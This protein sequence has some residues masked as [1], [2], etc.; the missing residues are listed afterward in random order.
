MAMKFE[1]PLGEESSYNDADHK[2]YCLSKKSDIT[3]EATG[4]SAGIFAEAGKLDE[5]IQHFLHGEGNNLG[6]ANGLKLEPRIYHTP[7]LMKLEKFQR[8]CGFEVGMKWP[9][10][11]QG[12]N[13]K[14]DQVM[15]RYKTGWDM[16]PLII[17]LHDGEYELNDGNHRYEALRRLGIEEHWVIIWETA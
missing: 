4:K 6:F 8:I 3:F 2:C 11:E 17:G 5:W 16:P 9:V 1:I 10:D 15:K 7:K 14:V 13:E 12:F